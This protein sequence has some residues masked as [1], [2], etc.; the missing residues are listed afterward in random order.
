MKDRELLGV[1]SVQ[2]R[3]NLSIWFV[4]FIND[5]C[6]N[7]ISVR[8][9]KSITTQCVSPIDHSTQVYVI[10]EKR[11]HHTFDKKNKKLQKLGNKIVKLYILKSVILDKKTP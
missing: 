10:T 4:H 8:V 7:D 9:I 6:E 1:V 11:N 5:V 3:S 2:A